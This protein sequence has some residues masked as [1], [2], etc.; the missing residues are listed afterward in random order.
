MSEAKFRSSFKLDAGTNT[1][2][3]AESTSTDSTSTSTS[4]RMM[5]MNNK[6]RQ[7]WSTLEHFAFWN[8]RDGFRDLELS[9]LCHPCL[10]C[11]NAFNVY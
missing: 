10:T 2:T 8:N 5:S 6:P 1:S 3:S 11:V 7:F 4:T 9:K